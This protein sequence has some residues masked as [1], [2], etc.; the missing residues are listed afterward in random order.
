MLESMEKRL[1]THLHQLIEK[2]VTPMLN[3]LLQEVAALREMFQEDDANTHDSID[4]FWEDPIMPAPSEQ[5]ASE[6]A[7]EASETRKRKRSDLRRSNRKPTR[8]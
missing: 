7:P 3:N 8:D 5:Q 6:Q 2:K 1:E 4:M